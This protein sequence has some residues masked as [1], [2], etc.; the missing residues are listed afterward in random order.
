MK[1]E[2]SDAAGVV[3][4]PV[5]SVTLSCFLDGELSCDESDILKAHLATCESCR[6]AY[7]ALSE[8]VTLTKSASAEAPSSVGRGV[9][10]FLL[11]ETRLRRL[12]RLRTAVGTAAAALVLVVG[13]S[14]LMPRLGVLQ[15]ISGSADDEFSLLADSEDRE[16]DTLKD[17]AAAGK[18][19]DEDT[20]APGFDST[21][22]ELIVTPTETEVPSDDTT[23][24]FAPLPDIEEPSESD[25]EILSPSSP[26]IEP[27]AEWPS[28]EDSSAGITSQNSHLYYYWNGAYYYWAAELLTP[29][30]PEDVMLEFAKEL[31]ELAPLAGDSA[32][33]K[34]ALDYIKSHS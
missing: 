25:A 23:D 6:A 14:F 10:D 29:T 16:N 19:T 2:R 32:A 4:C 27:P 26:E 20:P 7:E 18:P 30:L 5:D 24:F 13:I 12:R 34:E 17:S 11:R 31:S 33:Q 1:T 15:N 9:S 21:D 8:T 28:V 3:S 22:K